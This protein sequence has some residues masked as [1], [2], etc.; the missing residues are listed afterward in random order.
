MKESHVFDPKHIGILD[1]EDRQTWQNPEEIMEVLELKPSSVVADLGC[2]NGYFTVP[3]SRKVR[4][5]Y[6]I[7]VQKEMLEFFCS[8]EFLLFG[9][10]VLVVCLTIPLRC[11]FFR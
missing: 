11:D 8:L 2:G 9:L 7:D 3:I 5:V 6:G 10:I 4:K 1:S